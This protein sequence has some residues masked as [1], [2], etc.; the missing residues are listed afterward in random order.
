MH[1]AVGRPVERS[2][3]RRTVAEIVPNEF[4]AVPR[5]QPGEP[6]LLQ[7]QVVV[8]VD[9]V[10]PDYFVTRSINAALR[11]APMNPAAPGD[12]DPHA[13]AIT[14]SPDPRLAMKRVTSV[15]TGIPYAS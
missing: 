2:G 9:V 14:L 13:A 11:W 10:H 4:E 3:N 15:G 7:G 6:S 12:H 8:V 1:D 5:L